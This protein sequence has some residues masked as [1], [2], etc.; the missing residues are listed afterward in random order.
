MAEEESAEKPYEATPRKLEEARKR[1]EVPISQD[2][3]TFSVY[4][5]ILV[6]APLMGLWSIERAGSAGRLERRQR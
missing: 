3:I 6:T 1:G 4:V 5:G 2:L